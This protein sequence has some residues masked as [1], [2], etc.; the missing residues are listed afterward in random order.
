LRPLICDQSETATA[1]NDLGSGNEDCLCSSE[2]FE[3]NLNRLKNIYHSG[4]LFNRHPPFIPELSFAFDEKGA[5][6]GK[7]LCNSLQ[8]GYDEMVHGG[9]IA[10][11]ID[12]SMA[13]CLMGHGVIGYTADLSVRYCK[14]VKIS[15]H[16]E[17]KT[18][19]A[20]INVERLYTMKCEIVQSRNIVVKA[21]GK[22][23]KVK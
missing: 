1:S 5:L 9:I 16:T 22:F 20:A 8:Q 15:I 13:K 2:I 4:C 7:F 11:V 17:L 12:A 21:T 3:A 18:S 14:P 6:H 23:I 10:A 19:I